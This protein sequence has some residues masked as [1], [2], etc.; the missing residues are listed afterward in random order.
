VILVEDGELLP[1]QPVDCLLASGATL[2][3]CLV[4]KSSRALAFND[5]IPALAKAKRFGFLRTRGWFCHQGKCPM[6]IGR[7]IVYRDGGHITPEYA[8]KLAASFRTAFRQCLFAS[9]PT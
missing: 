9:C 3:S 2:G 1:V 4:T 8:Q 5:G 7:T 6:V